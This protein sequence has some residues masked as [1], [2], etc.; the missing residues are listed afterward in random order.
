VTFVQRFGGA[1]NLNVHFHCILPD[2]V[3]VR[4]DGGVR[5]VELPPPSDDE[6]MEVLRRVVAR[7][8]RLLRP[9]LA[10]RED[11]ARPLDALGAAQAEAMNSLGTPPPDEGRVRKRAAYLQ[12]FSLHAAVHLHANDREG[13]A[14][15]CGYGAR[16]PFSQE[17]LSQLPDGRLSYRLKRPLGDGRTALLLQPGELLRR[18]ATLV[19]PPRAHLLRYHGVFAPAS[20]WRREVVPRP[21]AAVEQCD[22]ALSAGESKPAPVP[23]NP[24]RIPW[25]ELL[26]RVFREDVLACPCGGRRV[27]LAYLTEPGPVKAI[28]DHLGLPSTGPPL[29]PA[30]FS[31]GPG[32]PAWQD[33]VPELQQSLR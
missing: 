13:L 11:D 30:R 4:D 1:L 24:C 14:H 21:L 18:L 28:L 31:A 3:F 22:P 26:L 23:R 17:R 10:S 5:F 16:P 27:V 25:A 29:A 19:P 9:R 8:E 6:V 12:G 7:L 33:D 20:R 32:E 15:L 2:G